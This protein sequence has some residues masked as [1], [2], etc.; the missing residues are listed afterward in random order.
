MKGHRQDPES[1]SFR[2]VETAIA[3]H[4]NRFFRFAY[5]LSGSREDAEDI[6]IE[7][8]AA[9][10]RNHKRVSDREAVVSWLYR[11]VLNQSRMHRRRRHIPQSPLSE[12]DY[13]GAH[14]STDH[15]ALSQAMVKLS[16]KQREA[17]VLVKGEGLTLHEAAAVLKRPVGT[18]SS[19]VSQGLAILRRELFPSETE[20][21]LIGR[22]KHELP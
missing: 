19:H 6:V 9:A 17:V 16:Q 5:S 3:Q 22:W 20:P 12:A 1:E 10:F 14:P 21:G 8:F 18:V 2:E 7:A 4:G 15:I 11:I 13:V